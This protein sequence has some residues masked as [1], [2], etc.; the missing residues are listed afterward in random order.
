MDKLDLSAPRQ[1]PVIL[2]DGRQVSG[3]NFQDAIF[4]MKFSGWRFQD[5][6]FRMEFI[7][8]N[9]QDEIF[10]MKFSGWQAGSR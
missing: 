3:W 1:V 5:G 4:R 7:G 10:R 9:F 8:W 2:Q 6:I